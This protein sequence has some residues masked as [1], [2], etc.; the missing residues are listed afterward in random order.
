[1]EMHLHLTWHPGPEKPAWPL[2]LRPQG[3][4]RWLLETERAESLLA[5][6]SLPTQGPF[7]PTILVP[8]SLRSVPCWT[9]SPA[10][11]A[12]SRGP[13]ASDPSIT[14]L[15]PQGGLGGQPRADGPR[16]PCTRQ[17]TE[18]LCFWPHFLQ[19]ITLKSPCQGGPP[20]SLYLKEAFLSWHASEN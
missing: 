6:G 3:H 10:S 17:L 5:S 12:L 19:V 18:A 15:V 8:L 20:G 11:R 14:S 9:L 2:T 13:W 16:G 1:M 7:Y 4:F